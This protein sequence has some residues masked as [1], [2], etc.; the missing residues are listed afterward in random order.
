MS[1]R[2]VIGILCVLTLAFNSC[3][4]L[5]QRSDTG[6]GLY[7]EI[8]EKPDLVQR[9]LIRIYIEEPRVDKALGARSIQEELR[10]LANLEVLRRGYQLAPSEGEADYRL[11][12]CAVERDFAQGWQNRRSL[13]LEVFMWRYSDLQ[14]SKKKEL[15]A[16]GRAAMVGQGSLSSSLEMEAL[17]RKALDKVLNRT[18]QK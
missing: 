3:A 5:P 9:G 6:W 8:G 10:R 18:L 1:H 4:V 14:S 13:S 17:L 12:L 16:I 7:P 2:F 11:D 15:V